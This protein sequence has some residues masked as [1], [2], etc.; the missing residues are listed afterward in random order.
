MNTLLSL[1][2]TIE[3]HSQTLLDCLKLEKKALEKNE[4][5][6]LNELT[7]KKQGML[8]LLQQLDKQRATH[9]NGDDFNA[10]I[11]NSKNQALITQWDKSRKLLTQCQ[12][13]N[14]VNG[15]L[16][17]RYSQMN[18]DLLSMLT[19]NNQQSAQTYNAQGN[20]NTNTSLFDGVSA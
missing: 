12:Q 10:Y 4:F 5:K 9:S 11:A 6:Q 7:N 1:L 19:G 16:L 20:Q 8:D 2:Q 14:E 13:R 15:R 18:H 3:Q 17:N